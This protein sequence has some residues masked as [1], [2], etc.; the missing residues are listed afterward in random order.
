MRLSIDPD[1]CVGAGQC[2]MF[3]PDVFD[4]GEDG[5]VELLQEEPPESAHEEVREAADMCPA[6]VIR[7]IA[8]AERP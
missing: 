2:A 1:K 4:Q 6:Q 7:L 8:H 5:I 3:A